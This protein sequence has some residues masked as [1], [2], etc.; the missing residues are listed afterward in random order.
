MINQSFS[1]GIQNIKVFYHKQPM[2]KEMREKVDKHSYK[3]N[4]ILHFFTVP[5]TLII[6]VSLPMS[7]SINI[8]SQTQ[9]RSISPH[10]PE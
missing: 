5:H 3:G 9:L 7:L 1:F 6:A 8:D 4:K 2:G 10:P